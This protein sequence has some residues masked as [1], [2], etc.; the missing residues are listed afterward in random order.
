[1]AKLKSGFPGERAIVLPF[2]IIDEFKKTELGALLH[3]TDIGY[4]PRAGFHFR[5]RTKDEANQYILI[6]CVEGEGWAETDGQKQKITGNQVVVLPKGK[7]HSY[8]SNERNPWTIYWM[9]MDGEKAA[10]FAESLEKPLL[11]QPGNDS[12]ME[13]RLKLFDEI[14][15]VLQ[16]GYSKQ[17]LDYSITALFYFFGSLKYLSTYRACAEPAQ[18]ARPRDVADEAIHF[19]RENIRKRLTLKEIAAYTGFSPSHFSTLFQTK[20]GHSP[21]NY[22]IQLK[23]QE[24]CHY[25]DFTDMK[26]NQISLLIGLED[27]FY[28]SRIFTKTMGMSPDKYRKIKKG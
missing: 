4:Y 23:M 27:P 2:P 1:M 3:I 28:F 14:F 18:T 12:R 24:A 25:I 10:F 11:I 19:M 5:K 9:H 6:Y 15:T 13:E 20:T 17:N 26:I 22:F 7:A 21:L 16:Y 8:G